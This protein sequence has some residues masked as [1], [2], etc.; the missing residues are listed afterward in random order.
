[1]TRPLARIADDFRDGPRRLSQVCRT[2]IA[3]RY[4]GDAVAAVQGFGC[5]YNRWR[6]VVSPGLPIRAIDRRPI[7]ECEHALNYFAQRVGRRVYRLEHLVAVGRGGDAGRQAL[8]PGRKEYGCDGSPVARFMEVRASV[9]V[10]PALV[11][12]MR[13]ELGDR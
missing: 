10:G 6:G 9:G 12:R 5:F 3:S 8:R 2:G 13:G 4:L 1:L 7:D 11:A